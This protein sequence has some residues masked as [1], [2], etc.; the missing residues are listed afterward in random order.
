MC[1]FPR[2]LQNYICHTIYQHL[3][4]ASGSA[5]VHFE[6]LHCLDCFPSLYSEAIHEL[7]ALSYEALKCDHLTFGAEL[8]KPAC[9]NMETAVNG[10]GLLQVVEHYKA[11]LPTKMFTFIHFSI[12]EFLTAYHVA[13]YEFQMKFVQQI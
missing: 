8:V 5:G 3:K 4:L 12:Q 2:G 6:D 7:S 9:T 13:P 10:F 1:I 11:G